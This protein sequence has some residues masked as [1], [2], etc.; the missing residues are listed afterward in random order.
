MVLSMIP[1]PCINVC[2]LDLEQKYCVGCL[3]TLDEIGRWGSCTDGEKQQI[4]HR[5]EH[6]G[7]SA[8]LVLCSGCGQGFVC[9][10]GGSK[11]G[12]WCQDLPPV[13][14]MPTDNGDCL[15]PDCLA[16]RLVLPE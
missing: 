9:G 11:G 14:P 8:R 7:L 4:W 1:S 15:C 16:G 13:M 2:K 3:R 10:Q 6:A 12:C 5:L